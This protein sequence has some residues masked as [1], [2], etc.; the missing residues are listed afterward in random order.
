MEALLSFS[1]SY[2][3]YSGCPLFIPVAVQLGQLTQ[4][5]LFL[6][7]ICSLITSFKLPVKYKLYINVIQ[8]YFVVL[9][10]Q[11]TWIQSV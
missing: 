4:N 6:G 2:L 5:P 11:L 8:I 9:S 1:V 7:N 3:F 10:V